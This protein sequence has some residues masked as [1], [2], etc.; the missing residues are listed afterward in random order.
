M[1]D[2]YEVRLTEF[3]FPMELDD[4]KLDF[5]VQIDLRYR[6][7]D[8]DF[9]MKTAILPGLELFWECSTNEKDKLAAQ[10]KPD[11]MYVRS[12]DAAAS[13]VDVTKIE[14]WY[15]TFRLQASQFYEMQVTVF[16]VERESWW[17]KLGGVLRDIRNVIVSLPVG[18]SKVQAG[19]F[20]LKSVTEDATS[21][22]G[23]RLAGDKNKALFRDSAT[24]ES[25]QWAIAGSNYS[26][27]FTATQ[28][29]SAADGTSFAAA[30]RPAG[31]ETRRTRR[32]PPKG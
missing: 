18:V 23:R 29:S 20:A 2:A 32:S 11:R 26:L 3:K 5:R 14:D 17:S 25:G 21:A 9:S 4:D 28:L 15:K 7:H 10:E 8:G 19:D 13:E 27:K 24:Y 30:A 12:D 22:I 31:P 1:K 6:D 16:D